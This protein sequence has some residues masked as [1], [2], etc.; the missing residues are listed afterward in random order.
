MLALAARGAAWA[1]RLQGLPR[2]SM[3]ALDAGKKGGGKKAKPSPEEIAALREA[4]AARKAAAPAKK[5][6]KVR[7][8]AAEAEA[9]RAFAVGGGAT[10][11]D[12]GANLQSR[13]SFAEVSRQLERA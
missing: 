10:V 13:G 8:P 12:I 9:L 1:P 3:S 2:R 5:Q 7:D 11:V 6:E 4:A